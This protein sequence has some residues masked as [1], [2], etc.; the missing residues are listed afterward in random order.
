MPL[1]VAY[2]QT[3]SYQDRAAG[4]AVQP[5]IG[6]GTF[7]MELGLITPLPQYGQGYG[8]G[9]LCCA[10]SSIGQFDRVIAVHPVDRH[11]RDG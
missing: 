8:L 5:G 3:F 7:T 9:V 6:Y 11:G 4:T 10:I 2:F 1:E